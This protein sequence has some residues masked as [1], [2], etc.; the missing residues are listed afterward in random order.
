[1]NVTEQL[2]RAW[3]AVEGAGLPEHLHE[4][5]FK[6]ALSFQGFHQDADTPQVHS[7][8]VSTPVIAPSAAP[9][10]PV[11]AVAPSIL[12]GGVPDA[13]PTSPSTDP[14]AIF[15]HETG[16]DQE[17]LEEVF[18]FHDGLPGLNGPGRK[19]GG[20]KT[21]QTRTVA[22]TLTAAY[23]FVLGDTSEALEAV[24]KECERQRCYDKVNFSTTLGSTKGLNYTGPRNN[25]TLKTKSDTIAELVA[26][27]A[28]IVK[29]ED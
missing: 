27:V 20:N 1:M 24:R 28:T 8:V 9:G 23:H 4:V 25:K 7:P 26:A 2:A 21:I 11:L 5:G 17:K 22:L 29:S 10:K 14:F 18:F 12:S 6:A 15:A 13:R 3:A 16:I 19:L